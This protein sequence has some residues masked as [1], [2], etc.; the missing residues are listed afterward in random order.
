MKPD[1]FLIG[2]PKKIATVFL[3]DFGLAKHY[4]NEVTEKHIPFKEGKKFIGT[5]RFA[6]IRTHEGYE[7]S[8]RDDLEG[9]CYVMIYF[10]RKSLPW[11]NIM[12]DEKEK[13]YEMIKKLKIKYV[14]KSLCKRL[15]STPHYHW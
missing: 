12:A 10:M 5:A 1:N 2:S 6:S 8:R 3:I 7:Q 11:R 14:S 4:L 15:P 13:K 9:M